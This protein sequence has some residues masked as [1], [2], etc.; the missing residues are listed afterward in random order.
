MPPTLNQ[1]NKFE[2]NSAGVN[3]RHLCSGREKS[4]T[5]SPENPIGLLFLPP[6]LLTLLFHPIFS[7]FCLPKTTP[8]LLFVVRTLQN[9]NTQHPRERWQQQPNGK[10]CVR[11]RELAYEH[12]KKFAL[13]NFEP[14]FLK[15]LRPKINFIIITIID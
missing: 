3:F 4:P 12:R 13:H 9:E 1:K 2:L 14:F 15:A 5:K 10:S 7:I 6:T 11:K 8:S